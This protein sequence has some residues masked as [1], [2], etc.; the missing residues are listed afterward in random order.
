MVDHTLRKYLFTTTPRW[1]TEIKCPMTAA[2]L[3]SMPNASL[4]V[5]APLLTW[6]S[7]EQKPKS[8][9]LSQLC[10]LFKVS[11]FFRH[12]NV[13]QF[14]NTGSWMLPTAPL[15]LFPTLSCS[16]SKGSYLLLGHFKSFIS[17]HLLLQ[18]NALSFFW[19]L[20][21]TCFPVWKSLFY[22]ES[23]RRHLNSWPFGHM[24]NSRSILILFP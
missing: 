18:L 17:L 7:A 14:S 5:N 22:L 10:F 4:I 9:N 2:V 21:T 8:L 24:C 1:S 16:C 20:W 13:L 6:L 15:A 23:P 12:S 3:G 19:Y 11:S